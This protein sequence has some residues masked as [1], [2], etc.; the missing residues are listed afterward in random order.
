M[1]FLSLLAVRFTMMSGDLMKYLF[2]D[3]VAK[4]VFHPTEEAVGGTTLVFMHLSMHP[5]A[6]L[7]ETLETLFGMIGKAGMKL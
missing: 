4:I 3:E 1:L 7:K 6:N 5:G 2:I